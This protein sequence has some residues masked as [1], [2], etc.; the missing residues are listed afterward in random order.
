MS[1]LT[2]EAPNSVEIVATYSET[3]RGRIAAVV[4][5]HATRAIQRNGLHRRRTPSRP[6][7]SQPLQGLVREDR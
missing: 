5:D 2:M 4:R 1:R 3:W 7:R 6:T